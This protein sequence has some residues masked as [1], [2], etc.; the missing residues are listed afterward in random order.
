[1]STQPIPVVVNNS[2]PPATTLT[3]E[4]QAQLYLQQQFSA[5]AHKHVTVSYTVIGVL[6]LV[7]ALAGVGGWLALKFADKQIERAEAAEQRFEQSTKD[8]QTQLAASQ[9]QRAADS[10]KQDVIVKV[11]H[12]TDAATDTK[13]QDVT[14]PGVT[15]TQAVSDLDSAYHGGLNLSGTPV[16]AD[17]ASFSTPTVQQFTATKLDRDRLSTDLTNYQGLLTIEQDKT[18]SL[19]TDLTSCQAVVKKGQDAVKEDKKAI[20]VT[21][22]KKFLNGAKET[23]IVVGSIVAGVELGKR[24]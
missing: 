12:D 23:V 3:A 24:L 9:T 8:L 6:V 19:T 22:W 16:T 5:L 13:I 2:T 17:G 21:K 10:A 18:K 20:V 15:A 11:V 4:Q 7:L 1:M 14:K